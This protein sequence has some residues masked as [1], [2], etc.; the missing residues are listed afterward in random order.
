M[1]SSEE[2]S[3]P[4]P[5]ALQ[6]QVEATME[7][8]PD[9]EMRTLRGADRLSGKVALVTGGD[10]G[11]GRAVAI[12]LATEGA[13]VALLYLDAHED[14]QET[15]RLVQAEGRLVM[16]ISGDIGNSGFCDDAIAQVA[17]HFG[18]IDILVTVAGEPGEELDIVG[19]EE[20]RVERVLR[21]NVL[22]LFFLALAALR[23]MTEGGSIITTAL[24]DRGDLLPLDHA[25]SMGAVAAFTRSLSGTLAR[26]A[27]RVN[28]VAP[29]PDSAPR[30]IA[31]IYVF[32]ASDDA[33]AMTGQVL[34][35]GGGTATGA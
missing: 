6:P 25:A 32:L 31:P 14:A 30:E 16:A 7:P 33:R 15:M 11:L 29:T 23:H 18:R 20:A 3:R 27:I 9:S 24:A 4:V 22:A 2:Q 26:R 17:A 12:G 13:D 10:S 28:A 8:Q 34:H 21:T 1:S 5:Q 19:I 35:P